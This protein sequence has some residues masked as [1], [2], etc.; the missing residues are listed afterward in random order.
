MHEIDQQ[1]AGHNPVDPVD[2]GVRSLV[3]ME[4]LPFFYRGFTNFSSHQRADF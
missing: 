2:V 4:H 1:M 3:D